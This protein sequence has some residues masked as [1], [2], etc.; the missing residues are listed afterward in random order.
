LSHPIVPIA[1]KNELDK[2]SDAE[3]TLR[4]KSR[5]LG[6]FITSK[7]FTTDKAKYFE[8][9]N[10]LRDNI[11]T[12]T[13]TI[14]NPEVG[15][16]GLAPAAKA[17]L[18]EE[19]RMRLEEEEAYPEQEFSKAKAFVLAVAIAGCVIGAW[20]G[21]FPPSLVVGVIFVIIALTYLPQIRSLLKS[22]TKKTDESEP[23]SIRM[24][25][26]MS[27]ILGKMRLHYQGYWLLSKVQNQKRSDFPDKEVLGMDEVLY[28]RN[29]EFAEVLPPE[30][31]T[32]LDKIMFACD[33]NIKAWK[34]FIISALDHSS[35]TSIGK[36]S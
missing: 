21:F 15:T 36:A 13:V 12:I 26:W 22:L 29:K 2:A 28:I 4:D 30:L 9:L 25:Q 1:L 3:K 6:E 16:S 35:Q 24:E 31:L 33:K 14:G 18:T 20:Q 19:E 34:S 7:I 8:L 17:M 23:V 5:A 10:G 32:D 11:V 27:V